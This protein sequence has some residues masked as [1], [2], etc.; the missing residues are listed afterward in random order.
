[1]AV[2]ILLAVAAQFLNA[3]VALLDKYIVTSERILPQPFV[4]AFYTC[5]LSGAS[6]LVYLLAAV[7]VPLEG[8]AFPSLANVQFPTLEV[9]ALSILAAYS[10]FYALV[11]MFTALQKADAS[12]VVPVIGAVSAIGSYILGYLFLDARL[13]S[14]FLLGVLVLAV[15]TALVSR[16]RFSL[17]VALTS[18]HAGLF[19]ALH[20]V[21]IKG[22]FNTTSFDDG[23]FWSRIGFV[24]FALS[25]LLVPAYASKIF[26]QTRSSGTQAGPFILV[27]KI[28]AGFASILI[29]K[30]TELGDVA[31]VQ[32]LGGLQYIF[33]FGFSLL[34][35]PYGPQI[36]SE[37]K[38]S[39]VELIHKAVF[40]AIISAGFFV[41]FL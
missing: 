32:A 6:I 7:P 41:L 22:L 37:G 24:V 3:I 18:L 29:L 21:V 30:A 4:Y 27:N 33:I 31:L 39:T 28:I 5:A 23:F 10:F 14:N 16:F 15:G 36:C 40:I 2:W 34:L 38:C 19:F 13:S 8:I 25:L 12:D 26:S 11:S 20:Y 9:I 17:S 1:M 35:G